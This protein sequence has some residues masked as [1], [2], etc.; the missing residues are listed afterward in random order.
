MALTEK[1]KQKAREGNPYEPKKLPDIKKRPD[2]TT[3]N[4]YDAG[5]SRLLKRPI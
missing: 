2:S 4:P 5:V 3:V 1:Q